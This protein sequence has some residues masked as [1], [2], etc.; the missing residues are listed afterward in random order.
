MKTVLPVALMA[1]ALITSFHSAKAQQSGRAPEYC[2]G[3]SPD[4]CQRIRSVVESGVRPSYCVPGFGRVDSPVHLPPEQLRICY[5]MPTPIDPQ[6]QREF[7]AAQAQQNQRIEDARAM[8]RESWSQ[9]GGLI[10][11][12]EVGYKCG[13]I[14]E[15]SAQLAI[16]SVQVSMDDELNRAGL[17]GDRAMNIEQTTLNFINTGK[18]SVQNGACSRLTPAMRGR[19]RAMVSSLMP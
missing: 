12:I 16:R 8:V 10:E 7:D 9:S 15:Q 6:H 17:I 18:A 5:A 2:V 13:V 14:D 3:F 1:T 4:A 11:G 19:L